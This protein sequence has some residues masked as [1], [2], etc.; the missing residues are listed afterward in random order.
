MQVTNL[1]FR[2]L[3]ILLA[4]WNNGSLVSLLLGGLGGILTSGVVQYIRYRIDKKMERE[5][6]QS[7]WYMGII[8]TTRALRRRAMD[9]DAS[10]ELDQPP[11]RSDSED[12]ENEAIARVLKLIEELREKHDRMPIEFYG[13]DVDDALSDLTRTYSSGAIGENDQSVVDFKRELRNETEG[14]L[15]AIEKEYEDASDLY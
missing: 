15:D 10:I 3:E 2:L 6:K 11:R 12:I 8:T 13:S 9:L 14:L 5:R 1:I 4:A 7:E